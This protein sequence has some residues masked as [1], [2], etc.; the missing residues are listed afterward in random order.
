[1]IGT[2]VSVSLS[3]T[4]VSR[5]HSGGVYVLY[6]YLSR[7]ADH[8]IFRR[9]KQTEK[10]FEMPEQMYDCDFFI[11][12]SSISHHW[13]PLTI[14]AFVRHFIRNYNSPVKMSI[15]Q[16]HFLHIFII[17]FFS[18]F[19]NLWH[20]RNSHQIWI[21][22]HIK[23]VPFCERFGRALGINASSHFFVP[24]LAVDRVHLWEKYTPTTG[25][26]REQEPNGAN[27]SFLYVWIAM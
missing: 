21:C 11:L 19:Y 16:I 6:V 22:W 13:I 14:R 10:F 12:L 9:V 17:Y 1:M 8:T 23:W 7:S 27:R 2:H 15:I 26:K 24:N 25:M 18:H 5:S 20:S 3:P 4:Y